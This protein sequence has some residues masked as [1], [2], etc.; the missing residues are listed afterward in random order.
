MRARSSPRSARRTT[1]ESSSGPVGWPL[2][3]TNQIGGSIGCG[4][5]GAGARGGSLTTRW[6]R[7][8]SA[9]STDA[10]TPESGGREDVDHVD[11]GA[12]GAG[13]TGKDELDGAWAERTLEGVA[14]GA[15]DGAVAGALDT[16]PAGGA[17]DR[18]RAA[19]AAGASNSGGSDSRSRSEEMAD[20]RTSTAGATR[21]RPWMGISAL[22]RWQVSFSVR[23]RTSSSETKYFA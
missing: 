14:G 5:G 19:I 23:P 11:S 15:L 2:Y 22:Q 4:G 20:R 10:A 13:V 6:R 3:A 16:V 12:G 17:L 21:G 8:V 1:S 7:G 18:T 9:G